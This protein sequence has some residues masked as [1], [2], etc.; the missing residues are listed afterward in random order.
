M[1]ADITIDIGGKTFASGLLPQLIAVLRRRRTG[2]LVAL[3]GDDKSIGPELET[4][5]RFTGNAF[6]QTEFESGRY[7]WVFRYGT[8]AASADENRP[9]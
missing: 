9:V 1:N 7:R 2:D 4:W 5:C 8:V 6:L 3:V